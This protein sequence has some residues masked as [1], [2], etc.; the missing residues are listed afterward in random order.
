MFHAEFMI[1]DKDVLKLHYMLASMK[2]FE[3]SIR[4]V[5][6]AKL[7]KNG[8][9]EGETL[10]GTAA[11]MVAHK[12]LETVEPGIAISRK[13]VFE[14]AKHLGFSPNS[15]LATDL[16]AAKVLKKKGRGQ[17]ILLASKTT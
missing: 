16:V 5:I 1:D 17:F 15:K 7:G 6:N 14:I 11:E 8:K 2:V 3:V 10:T 13:S 4:P 12:L 9:V